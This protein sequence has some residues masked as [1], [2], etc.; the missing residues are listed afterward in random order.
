ML[1]RRQLL[2]NVAKAA[3][4]GAA[5]NFF[6]SI[7]QKA[8][9]EDAT[10]PKFKYAICNEVFGDWPFAKAFEFAAKCGYTGVEIAPFTMAA[11]ADK[12]SA[13]RRAD[14]RQQAKHAGLEVVGLHWLLA[15]TEGFHLTSPDAAVRR[16]TAAY[17]GELAHLCADLGG[18]IMVLGS[19]QQRSLAPGMTKQQGM[20]FAAEVLHAAVPTL[21][22]TGVVVGLEPLSTAET[23]FL[24]TAAEGMELVSLVDSPTCRLHLDCKAMST[25]KTPIPE[26]IHK[27]RK[28]FIHFHANDPN[29]QGPGFGKLD[30]VPIM[31]A[32]AEISYRGW[33]SVEPTDYSAGPER[34]ARESIAYL[35]RCAAKDGP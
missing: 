2:A 32:L 27:Y 8:E 13:A 19:P 22:K 11:Y 10:V 9:A 35:Q 29:R 24:T 3:G 14:V 12:I 17:L 25:E 23:N 26:I 20:K 16:K 21:E 18:R 15:K 31:K 6:P 1:T 7:A 34:L 33:V 30:F 5:A 28:Q 4:F